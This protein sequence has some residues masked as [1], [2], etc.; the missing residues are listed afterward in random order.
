MQA[1]RKA[2]A[3]RRISLESDGTVDFERADRDWAANTFA[4]AVLHSRPATAA[5][6]PVQSAPPRL[7]PVQQY[8]IARAGKETYLAKQA[9]LDYEEKAGKLMPTQK[10]NEYAATFS[11]LIKDHLLAMPDRLAPILAS[12]DDAGTAHKVVAGDVQ[13][14]LKKLSKAISDAGL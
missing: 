8:L 12:I 4:G 6:A 13:I 1:V 7:D 10:A 11:A 2:I 3:S 9:Q 14:V 5:T